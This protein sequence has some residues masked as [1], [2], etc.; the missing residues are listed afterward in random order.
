MHTSAHHG[1]QG[2]SGTANE[3][4]SEQQEGASSGTESLSRADRH[5]GAAAHVVWLWP[6]PSC[7]AYT[8]GVFS[9]AVHVRQLPRSVQGPAGGDPLEPARAL[10]EERKYAGCLMLLDAAARTSPPLLGVPPQQL[11]AQT[12]ICSIHLHAE[13]GAWWQVTGLATATIQRGFTKTLLHRSLQDQ[14]S[15]SL[16]LGCNNQ[17]INQS[18]VL[19]TCSVCV[20]A[21]S[22]RFHDLGCALACRN[23]QAPHS[24]GFTE[25]CAGSFS[26]SVLSFEGPWIQS[27]V[28]DTAHPCAGAGR[29][30]KRRRECHPAPVPAPGAAGASRQD[31][32]LRC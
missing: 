18:A 4:D 32:L 28:P 7:Y 21:G 13:R 22:L 23:E 31:A 1:A 16:F 25:L 30:R 3:D 29:S 15:V 20:H 10:F 19:G 11:Q 17:H 8:S 24:V 5:S 14:R 2:V 27:A 9:S 6:A 26:S 12:L